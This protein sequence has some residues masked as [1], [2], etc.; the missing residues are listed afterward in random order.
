MKH[1]INRIKQ[2]VHMWRMNQ[3]VSRVNE[4]NE[5]RHKHQMSGQ[6]TMHPEWFAK[7]EADELEK[8]KLFES[9]MQTAMP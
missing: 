7:W 6:A 3:I 2:D 1:R 5:R 9:T 4:Y 8:R